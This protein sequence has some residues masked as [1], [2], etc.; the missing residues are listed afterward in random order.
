[1]KVAAEDVYYIQSVNCKSSKC[2][3][4]K[5]IIVDFYEYIQSRCYLLYFIQDLY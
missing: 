2:R 1:M 3:S 4:Q 5:I